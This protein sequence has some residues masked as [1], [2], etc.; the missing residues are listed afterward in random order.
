MEIEQKYFVVTFLKL[1][2]LPPEIQYAHSLKDLLLGLRVANFFRRIYVSEIL[3]KIFFINSNL[4]A[5]NYE[6]YL[7][8]YR[9]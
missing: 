3:R 1:I 8:A 2:D 9:T 6:D 4:E 7:H 5:T